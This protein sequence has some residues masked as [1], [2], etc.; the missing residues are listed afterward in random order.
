MFL[1]GIALT[2]LGVGSSVAIAVL[3]EHLISSNRFPERAYWLIP[4]IIVMWPWAAWIWYATRNIQTR[5]ALVT[6]VLIGALGLGWVYRSTLNTLLYL[7]EPQVTDR[8]AMDA[9]IKRIID[10]DSNGDPNAKNEHLNETGVELIVAPVS[11]PH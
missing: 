2:W 7:E 4:A 8:A 3:V 9:M 5:L 6:I 1:I 10:A 11:T